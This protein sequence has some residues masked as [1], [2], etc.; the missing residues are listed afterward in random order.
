MVFV[1]RCPKTVLLSY[2]VEN[3]LIESVVLSAQPF[4]LSAKVADDL[5]VSKDDGVSFGQHICQ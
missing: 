4:N 1:Q 2:A 3:F 5:L